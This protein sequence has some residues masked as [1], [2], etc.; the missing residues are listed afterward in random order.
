[1]GKYSGK[2][3]YG[4]SE[5]NSLKPGEWNV[6]ETPVTYKGDILKNKALVR[7]GDKINDDRLLSTTV[8]I[9]ADEFTYTNFMNIMYVEYMGSKWK[10]D[11]VEILPPRLLITLGGLYNA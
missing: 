10:V 1:M 3:V 8:S 9:V 6:V 2:I 4:I 5:E 7:Q 11:S